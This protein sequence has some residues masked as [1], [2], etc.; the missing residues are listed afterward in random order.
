MADTATEAK[1]EFGLSNVFYAV[2]DGDTYTTPVPIKGGVKMTT[3]PQS[4]S[5][6]FYADNGGYFVSTVNSG[7]T[8]TLTI[9]RA[10]KQF[11]IDCLGWMVDDNGIVLETAD[12]KN[13]EVALLYQVE[14]DQDAEK[15]VLY[16]VTFSAAKNEHNTKEDKSDP[17]TVDL[18]FTAIPVDFE[19]GGAVRKVIGGYVEKA[20]SK[21]ADWTTNVQTPTKLA[22]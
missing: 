12:G 17:D 16:D 9:A 5:S 20:S 14:T 22:V 15:F 3:D 13:A 8:G 10:P 4:D 6:T 18:D 2:K 21:Y 19:L 11:L 7:R 1:V